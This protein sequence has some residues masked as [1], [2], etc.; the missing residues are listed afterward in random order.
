MGDDLLEQIQEQAKQN[1]EQM[2]GGAAAEA[3]PAVEEVAPPVVEDILADM[4]AQDVEVVEVAAPAPHAAPAAHREHAA[5]HAQPHKQRTYT[6]K[7][8]DTLSAIGAHFGVSWQKIAQIN[9]VENPDLIFPGQ[10]FV[11]PD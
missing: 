6:V 9:H 11:I 2:T 7:S 3:P 4:A 5:P 8:G 1:A 10:T